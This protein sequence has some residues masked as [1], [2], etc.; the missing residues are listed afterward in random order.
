MAQ[1][2]CWSSGHYICMPP[3]RQE[4]V[5]KNGTPP[6]FQIPSL[7]LHAP[8]HCQNVATRAPLAAGEQAKAVSLLGSHLLS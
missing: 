8:F 2:G 4:E 7:M 3:S 5:I 6:P 1:C